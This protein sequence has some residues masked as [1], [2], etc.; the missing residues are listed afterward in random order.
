LGR[1]GRRRIM[2]FGLQQVGMI[3]AD[4]R[5]LDQDFSRAG[6]WFGYLPQDKAVL[7][8][9]VFDRDRLHDKSGALSNINQSL[10]GKAVPWI[11]TI[12]PRARNLRKSIWVRISPPFPR[13]SWK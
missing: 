3:K 12:S 1:A 9:G 2:A 13:M 11:A 4:A 10:A 5:H 6:L 7:R 8:P